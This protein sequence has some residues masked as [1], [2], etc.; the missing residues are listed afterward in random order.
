MDSPEG[1][2]TPPDISD[3]PKNSHGSILDRRDYGK[4]GPFEEIGFL[5]QGDLQRDENDIKKQEPRE[6]DAFPIPYR[7][8]RHKNIN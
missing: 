1:K 5:A 8:K 7:E 6:N 2:V 4:N 3:F